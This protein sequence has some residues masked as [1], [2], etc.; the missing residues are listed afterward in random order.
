M[1]DLGAAKNILGLEIRRERALWRLWLHHSGYVRKVLER[2]SMENSKLV[3][4]PLVNHFRLSTTQCPKTDDDVQD[5]SKV[6]YASAVGCLM[7]VMV[8]T[9]LDLTQAV[10]LVSKF[11]SNPG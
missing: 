5:M 3:S 2:F 9:R 4:T 11:L 1:K 6:P 8:C 7:Y 10:S